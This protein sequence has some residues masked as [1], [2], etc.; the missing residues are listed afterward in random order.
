M[1]VRLLLVLPLLG[2]CGLAVHDSEKPSGSNSFEIQCHNP[3]ADARTYVTYTVTASADPVDTGSELT[4]H[5]SAPPAEVKTDFVTPRFMESKVTYPVPAGFQLESATTDPS[6]TKDINESDV[7]VADG[8][9]VLH[10]TGSFD[11][12]GKPHD[13]PELVVRGKVTAPSGASVAWMTPTELDGKASAGLIG[14]Q[15]STC[16]MI[17]PGPIWTIHVR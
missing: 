15:D 11:L 10:E 2:G 4:L 5:I 13:M 12:D 16:H 3:L 6:T 1:R 9:I 7:N 17:S 14:E 8:A